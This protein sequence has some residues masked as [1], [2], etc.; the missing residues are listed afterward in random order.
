[1]GLDNCVLPNTLHWEQDIEH[2]HHPRKSLQAPFRSVPQK[3]LLLISMIMNKYF[4]TC[5]FHAW[6]PL[7]N[8]MFFEPYSCCHVYQLLALSL[9]LSG[10]YSISPAYPQFIYPFPQRWTSGLYPELG[11]HEYSC[12]GNV[13]A[14]LFVPT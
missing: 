1:M 8:S 13:W 3:Q 10:I 14:N 4:H 9:L 6:L 12:C 5:I 11:Y 2:F 7:L